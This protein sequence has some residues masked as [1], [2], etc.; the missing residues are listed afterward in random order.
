MRRRSMPGRK[1]G[2]RRKDLEINFES[3]SAELLKDG[4]EQ[5]A[6][7]AQVMSRDE[8]RNSTFNIVG[9]TDTVGTAESNLV[10]SR[11]RAQAIV[12]I[13][14]RDYGIPLGQMKATGAGQWVLK[15][16]ILGNVP[17]NRRVEIVVTPRR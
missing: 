7:L 2:G 3:G 15:V 5:V 16:P 11:Q 6:S 17:A 1:L 12:D 14:H 4:R 9:H 8:F 10:L 13:L